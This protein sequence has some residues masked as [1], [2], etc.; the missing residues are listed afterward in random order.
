MA[1]SVEEANN[2]LGVVEDIFPGCVIDVHL[3]PLF[4]CVLDLGEPKEVNRDEEVEQIGQTYQDKVGALA[5]V[6]PF[7]DLH[8]V[9]HDLLGDEAGDW[10]RVLGVVCGGDQALEHAGQLNHPRRAVQLRGSKIFNQ[11]N[12]LFSV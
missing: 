5:G 12:V 8:Q 2:V 9:Q 3:H 6:P 7:N 11:K 1:G 4:H 10:N